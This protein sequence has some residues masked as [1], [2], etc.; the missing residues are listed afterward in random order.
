MGLTGGYPS[1]AG[2][3]GRIRFKHSFEFAGIFGTPLTENLTLDFVQILS[4]SEH[5]DH[6]MRE[7]NFQRLRV[8]PQN[9][10]YCTTGRPRAYP[11]VCVVKLLMV[12]ECV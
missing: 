4:Q 8:P 5:Y 3:N 9:M 12:N 11:K 7:Y 2:Y 1:Q 6:V 10:E